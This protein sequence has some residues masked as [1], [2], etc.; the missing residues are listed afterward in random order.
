ML[1]QCKATKG[2][3]GPEMVRELEGAVGAA[4]E[5]GTMGVLCGKG[6]VTRG[7]RDAVKRSRVGVVWIRVC[8]EGK[9][10][11]ILWSRVAG[12]MV[13]VEV[14]LRYVREGDKWE[15]EAVL[16]WRG[17]VWGPNEE[18]EILKTGLQSNGTNRSSI[19]PFHVEAG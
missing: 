11:Q 18:D 1:V 17:E 3:A 7:V 2:K 13:G 12:E 6:E 19:S 8:G 4:K 9:V 15:K 16:K 5:E 14:G 10:R